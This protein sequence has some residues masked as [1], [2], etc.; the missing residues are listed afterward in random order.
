MA[1][2]VLWHIEVGTDENTLALHTALRAQV[3]KADEIHKEGKSE[4]LLLY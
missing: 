1:L 2:V 4:N 3:S